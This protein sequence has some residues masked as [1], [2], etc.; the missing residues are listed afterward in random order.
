MNRILIA[1]LTLTAV[2]AAQE[3][4]RNSFA[5]FQVISQ[6]NIFDPNREPRRPGR[7]R[8]NTNHAPVV[9]AFSLVGI[10]SYGKGDFAFFDGTNSEYRKILEPAGA[11]AGYKVSEITSNS[12]K[13]ENGKQVV[14]MKVG[15]QMQREEET[16]RLV[17]HNELPAA[18]PATSESASAPAA[19]SS[20]SEPNEILKRLMQQ[21]EQESK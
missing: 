15:T 20:A 1:L 5:A 19:D 13:L 21:R 6:R 4:N 2:A 17:A 16:W 11:I 7:T 3:T 10:M 9:D 18:A 12:V 8:S 14:Q